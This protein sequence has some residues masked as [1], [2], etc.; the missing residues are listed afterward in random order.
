MNYCSKEQQANI[1]YYRPPWTCGRYD[2]EHRVA[3]FYNLLEGMSYFFEDD[4]AEIIGH[5]LQI[6]RNDYIALEKLS[7][8]TDTEEECLVDFLNLLIDAGLL[9]NQAITANRLHNYRHACAKKKMH[10]ASVR[11]E[12]PTEEKL[13]YIISTSESLY[14]ERIGGITSVMLELTYNCS[15]KCIHCYNIGATRNDD[16][17]SG[18]NKLEELTIDDYR[19]VLDQLYDKGLVKVCLSGGDPFSKPAIWDIIDYLYQK[20]IAFDIFTNGQQLANHEYRLASY[21]PRLV[22]ISIYSSN[23]SEHDYITRVQ[24]SWER[25]MSTAQMLASLSVPLNIK[26]CIMRP[27]MKGYRGVKEIAQ[28]LGGAVQY[29]ISITDSIE[30]DYCATKY[31]RLTE[32]EMEI[33]L[34]DNNLKLYVGKEAPQY[35]GIQ[36]KLSDVACG[37]GEY[38][39][40]LTPDGML[41]PCCAFHL[42]FGNVR[43]NSVE[44]I[45]ASPIR[46]TWLN[47]T[48]AD[49]EECGRYEYC[50]Y[51]NLCTGNNLSENGNY[52]NAAT[53]NNCWLAQ[54][55][56]NL[57]QKMANENYDPLGGKSIDEKIAELPNYEPVKLQR[58]FDNRGG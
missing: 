50:N 52:L 51:C 24:G 49:Y 46:R 3:L 6:E 56:Y 13:P 2:V 48:L 25:S 57:A 23:P 7:K 9:T 34:C 32:K 28:S 22:G 19:R 30:G 16:E 14:S 15:E 40:T 44:E 41:I 31:L 27:N 45:L 29:E 26:C 17:K 35:G 36:R 55:R 18:R 47:H 43:E 4:S 58:L 12:L 42:N 1:V 39:I 5:L 38:S 10:E 33:I 8:D 11:I 20:N 37:A 54:I 21:Y 53:R